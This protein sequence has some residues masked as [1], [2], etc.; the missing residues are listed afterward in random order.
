MMK[1]MKKTLV[2]GASEKADRYAQKAINSLKQHGHEV[3]ALGLREGNFIGIPIQVGQPDFKD[4]N[5]VTLYVG[6]KNQPELYDYVVKL[7]PKRVVFNP[8]TENPYFEELLENN[9]I[10]ALEACTLVMLSI[11]N[12]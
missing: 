8:G 10:Q 9:G 12:Y 3:F 2:I 1:E 7:K 5:T 11:G 4:I 6:P